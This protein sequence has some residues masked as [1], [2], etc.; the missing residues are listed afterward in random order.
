MIQ[1]IEK[2]KYFCF[3]LINILTQFVG[4]LGCPAD[5][6][7][8]NRCFHKSSSNNRTQRRSLKSTPDKSSQCQ[9]HSHLKVTTISGSP[10]ISIWCGGPADL[11]RLWQRRKSDWGRSCVLH[12]P[13]QLG[14]CGQICLY[15]NPRHQFSSYFFLSFT[16]S[17]RNSRLPIYR[18]SQNSWY[19]PSLQKGFML[20][21]SIFVRL[22]LWN[23]ASLLFHNCSLYIVLLFTLV[24]R[25]CY[26]CVLESA[27]ASGLQAVAVEW[28]A[29][30]GG[31]LSLYLL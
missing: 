28:G 31:E 8:H 22:N 9:Y 1:I 23:R 17:S 12:V 10:C 13:T 4:F 5:R 20:L 7:F 6:V 27:L 24:P 21:D 14:G 19:R 2:E 3:C 16:P 25:P 26:S 11:M 18:P 29:T 30:E 15:L